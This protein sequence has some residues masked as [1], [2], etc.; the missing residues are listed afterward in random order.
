MKRMTAK[1]TAGLS[2]VET[3]LSTSI[4]SILAVAAIPH[5]QSAVGAAQ[6]L[7]TQAYVHHVIKGVEIERGNVETTLPERQSCADLT[8]V[9]RD[10]ASVSSCLYEPDMNKDS[11]T[12]TATSVTGTTFHYDGSEVLRLK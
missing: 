6:D 10:P 11:Y 8:H 9:R 2:V 3:L 7:A 1:S 12:V 5:L 4:L